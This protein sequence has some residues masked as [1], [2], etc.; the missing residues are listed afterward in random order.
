MEDVLMEIRRAG[1]G[2]P[3]TNRRVE[4][5]AVGKVT[6]WYQSNGWSVASVERE[7][8]GYDLL[9]RREG[10]EEHVEV[11]GTQGAVPAFIVTAN[12]FRVSQVDPDFRLCVVTLALQEEA[13]IHTYRGTEL[14]A[15]FS[16]DALAYRATRRPETTDS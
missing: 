6:E 8:C 13:A 12:E 11:K 7:N 3:A 1:F 10:A 2:D 4:V 14:K 15:H 5:A 9:C 16:F